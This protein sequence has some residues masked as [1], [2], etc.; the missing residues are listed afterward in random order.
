MK[1]AT[2]IKR[3]LELAEKTKGY[4]A[5]NPMVGALLVYQDVIIGEGW[6]RQYGTAHAEV[7]CIENVA[8]HLKHLIPESTLYVSLEPCAHYGKTPPCALRLINER[9]KKVVICNDDPFH[10]VAGR[11]IEMLKQNG[12]EVVKNVLDTEGKWLNRR[13]FCFHQSKRPYIILKWA[14]TSNGFFAPADRSRFQISNKHSTQLVHQW[15]TEESA[16]LVGFNTALHDNP[17][18]TARSF[19]GRQPLRIALDKDLRL[20]ETHQLYST[21]APTWII[22]QHRHDI[23]S[24]PVYIKTTFD[25]SI[26]TNILSE[27]Y[28]ANIQSLIVEGG[29]QVLTSFIEQ[30]LWDEARVF[31]APGTLANGLPAPLLPHCNEVMRTEIDNDMLHVYT[32][33]ENP[34]SYI[35]GM[36]L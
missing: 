30:D 31:K 4:T 29:A 11:G 6:H 7:N 25:N 17:Q 35:P 34:F 26:L 24:Q 27:L 5:P 23:T 13:F 28:T 3:C 1:D 14:E 33:L 2:Y 32:H 36:S 12:I 10:R 15:R 8:A 19:K 20:P 18:L 9:V 21:A 22:N 16:I